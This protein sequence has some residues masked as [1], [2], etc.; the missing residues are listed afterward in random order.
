MRHAVHNATNR[1]VHDAT[2][3]AVN[4]RVPVSF[5]VDERA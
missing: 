2:A 1:Q 3:I 5:S 4:V